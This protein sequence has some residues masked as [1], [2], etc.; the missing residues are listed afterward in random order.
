MLVDANGVVVATHNG[1]ITAEEL[2][3]LIEESG[4]IE[5]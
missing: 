4:M 2:T 5:K 1:T 3:D